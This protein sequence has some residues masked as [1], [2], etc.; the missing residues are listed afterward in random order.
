VEGTEGFADAKQMGSWSVAATP[1]EWLMCNTLN[2]QVWKPTFKTR[3]RCNW[4]KTKISYFGTQVSVCQCMYTWMAKNASSQDN[5][6]GRNENFSKDILIT[7]VHVQWGH[8]S[9]SMHCAHVCTR[10]FII[11]PNLENPSN[12]IYNLLQR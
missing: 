5:I 11:C 12:P 4:F 6:H 9:F 1:R 10:L 3:D 7:C 2:C 8:T